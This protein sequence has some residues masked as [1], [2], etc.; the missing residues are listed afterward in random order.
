MPTL[1]RLRAEHAPALLAFERDNR[2]YFAR[3]I[4]DRGDAYFTPSGFAARHASLLAEQEA[5]ACHFH[6]LLEEDGR[7]VGR[8][9]LIDVVDGS[10]ELGYRVGERAAGRGVATAA[11]ARV[12]RLAA[13][14]YGLTTLTAVT[15]SDHPASMTVLTRNGFT[16][17]RDITVDGRPGVSYVRRDLGDRDAP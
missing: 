2:A 7:V 9:N 10:A 4:P 14:S 15:T 13:R 16:R 11:V 5:G 12:C 1:E 3:S 8:V 17:V 6:V